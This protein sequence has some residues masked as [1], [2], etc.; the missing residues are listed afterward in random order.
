[1]HEILEIK[2][3]TVTEKGQICIPQLARQQ[4][5]LKE[6]SKVSIIVYNDKIELIPMK[7]LSKRLSTAIASE[8]ALAKDWNSKEDEAAWKNL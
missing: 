1:M 2:T 4:A 3:A 5:G 7:K 6:G 8:K